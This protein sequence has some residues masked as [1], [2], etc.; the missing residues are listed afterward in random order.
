M[1]EY[2][3]PGFVLIALRKR[4]HFVLEVIRVKLWIL[5]VMK[6]D[7]LRPPILGRPIEE[8]NRSA[9]RHFVA[10]DGD[11]PDKVTLK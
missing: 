6:T 9:D 3:V 8:T 4:Y 11:S 7:R 1:F 2:S 10:G 5:E